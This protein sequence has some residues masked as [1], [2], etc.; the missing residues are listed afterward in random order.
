MYKYEFTKSDGSRCCGSDD[1]SDS[2]FCD[3]CKVKLRAYQTDAA[4][5]AAAEQVQQA[6]EKRRTLRAA[7]GK[8]PTPS[9]AAKALAAASLD[10]YA[11]PIERLRTAQGITLVDH[12]A[13]VIARGDPAIRTAEA[14]EFSKDNVDKLSAIHDSTHQ[15]HDLA[16]EAGAVCDADE[17]PLAGGHSAVQPKP[18]QIGKQPKTTIAVAQDRHDRSV[19]DHDVLRQMISDKGVKC[20]TKWQGIDPEQPKTASTYMAPDSYSQALDKYRREAH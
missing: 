4:R 11:K 3:S 15:S 14:R 1:P 13:I 10:I 9:D 18:D 8:P 12:R 6:V 17:C 16:V 5:L 20:P 19:I 2:H 7:A